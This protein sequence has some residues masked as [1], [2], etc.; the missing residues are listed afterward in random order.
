M[1]KFKA[2]LKTLNESSRVADNEVDEL[3]QQYSQYI[4]EAVVNTA[5]SHM[6]VDSRSDTVTVYET[7]KICLGKVLKK[8]LFLS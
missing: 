3:L 8:S 1:Q 2:V 5:T 4:D 6:W 7:V